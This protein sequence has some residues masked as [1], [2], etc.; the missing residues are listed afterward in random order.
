MLLPCMPTEFFVAA[1]LLAQRSISACNI[2]VA[3]FRG[4]GRQ[5]NEC[6]SLIE[7]NVHSL[8]LVD[9]RR[10]CQLHVFSDRSCT[11]GWR[12][13]QPKHCVNSPEGLRSWS[14]ECIWSQ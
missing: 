1:L 14:M 11:Q 7:E 2:H 8:T 3:D 10:E 4:F 13:V 6:K 9:I 5:A 12:V